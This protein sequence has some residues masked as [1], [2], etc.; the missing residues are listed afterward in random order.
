MEAPQLNPMRPLGIL[1]ITQDLGHIVSAIGN[2]KTPGAGIK[3]CGT[4]KSVQCLIGR[5]I[6]FRSIEPKS[7]SWGLPKMRDPLYGGGHEDF[8]SFQNR[9]PCG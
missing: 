5:R 4:N 3:I 7:G 8:S 2:R 1:V 9:S 6:S